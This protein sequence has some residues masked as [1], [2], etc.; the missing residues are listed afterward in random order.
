M[1]TVKE[2]IETMIQSRSV[3]TGR[4]SGLSRQIIAQMNTLLDFGQDRG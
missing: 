2:A 4:V 1:T 3:D